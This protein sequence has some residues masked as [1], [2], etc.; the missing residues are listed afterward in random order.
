M[1]G[2]RGRVRGGRGVLYKDQNSAGLG[3][4][5][6]GSGS[7]GDLQLALQNPVPSLLPEYGNARSPPWACGAEMARHPLGPTPPPAFLR[8]S[9]PVSGL[10]FYASKWKGITMKIYVCSERGWFPSVGS[11]NR[12][13]PSPSTPSGRALGSSSPSARCV[14][15]CLRINRELSLFSLLPGERILSPSPDPWA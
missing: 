5:Q 8:L 9:Y 3:V 10:I 11:R 13:F 7:R 6:E 2:S 1:L 12:C 15:P 4:E 14:F